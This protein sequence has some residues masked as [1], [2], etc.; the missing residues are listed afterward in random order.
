[1]T[2]YT[3]P[4]TIPANCVRRG[5]EV[6]FAPG[7]YG[8]PLGDSDHAHGDHVMWRAVTGIK[9]GTR[10]EPKLI[11]FDGYSH[12][13][14]PDDK[15][16]VC[17]AVELPRCRSKIAHESGAVMQCQSPAGHE[18]HAAGDVRWFSNDERALHG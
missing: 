6:A 5:D 12:E 3:K 7:I 1:M 15:V 4:R 14:W 2:A 16:A 18:Q 11:R 9:A 10:D 17:E 8:Q 13:F